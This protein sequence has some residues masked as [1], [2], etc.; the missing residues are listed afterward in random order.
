MER[1]EMMRHIEFLRYSL[2]PETEL[3]LD[4]ANIDWEGLYHFASEQAILGVVVEGVKR[5]KEKGVK[6]PIKQFVTWIAAADDIAEQNKKLNQAVLRLTTK[7]KEKG[8]QTCILKGQGN[9][10]LYPNVYART[11]GDIDVWVKHE[12]I[13]EKE[14]IGKVIQYVKKKNHRGR[15]TYHHIEIGKID[16]IDVELH[17][18]PSF[19]NSPIHNHRLQKW[20]N[21]Q[22][23]AQFGHEIEG[24]PDCSEK[25]CVPTTYFNIVFLLS[26]IYRHLLKEGIGLRQ[27]IDYFFLLRKT[28]DEWKMENGELRIMLRYLG[29][30]KIAGAMMWVLKEVLGME[31]KF[32]IVPP[33]EKLG[34]F[35]LDEIMQGGNFGRYDVRTKH[36]ASRLSRNIERLQ[37]DVRL[38][39]YFPSECLW[40]PVFRIYHFFWRL[41]YL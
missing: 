13:S 37:R 35:L 2:N 4:S 40:E 32:L 21:E 39:W 26:H 23:I 7:L 28:K 20:F 30:W 11:P 18:R 8:Q 17:I 19:M 22:A 36:S 15:V 34:V 33:N 10:L 41:P 12:G 27:V 3:S 14:Y 25:V 38:V 5:L 16:G 31:E 1:D 24:L 29:L 6:L 9:N